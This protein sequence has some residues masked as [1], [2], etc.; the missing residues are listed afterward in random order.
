MIR[1]RCSHCDKTLKVPERK[2]GASIACPRC[3]GLC[4]VPAETVETDPEAPSTR[5]EVHRR[6]LS[7]PLLEETPSLLSGMSPGL[8]WAVGLVAGVGLFSLLLAV[9]A[10]LV[11]VLAAVSPAANYGAMV[12]VPV[13]VSLLLAVLYGHA[14]GCPSCGQ[15][16]SR[17]NVQTE[18]VD[19]ELFEKGGVPFARSIYRTTYECESCRHRWL[20]TSVEEFKEAH[21]DRDRDRT[22]SR[23]S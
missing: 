12:V 4:V 10:A 3:D 21:R 22:R 18:F 2:A 13:S 8:R 6:S 11:P 5:P 23:P 16:W 15:W 20:A 14:T 7:S 9:L 17:R 1:F 19:K